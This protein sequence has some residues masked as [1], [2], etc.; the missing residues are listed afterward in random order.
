MGDSYADFRTGF[1][2]ADIRRMLRDGRDRKHVTRH[3]VLGKWR[4]I[5]LAMFEQESSCGGD[6]HE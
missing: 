4:E 5:K 1:S 6:D 2:F 3:T